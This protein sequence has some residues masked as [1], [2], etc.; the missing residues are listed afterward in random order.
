RKISP[1]SIKFLSIKCADA[2][3]F[4]LHSHSTALSSRVVNV[5]VSGRG[6]KALV[7]APTRF[8][9]TL[10]RPFPRF[11]LAQHTALAFENQLMQRREERVIAIGA[12]ENVVSI[13]SARHQF[14]LGQG[15]QL[16]LHSP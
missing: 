1:L 11:S 4:P 16:P 7:F 3:S 6:R 14:D 13:S 12:V 5:D 15:C 8:S 10:S 9:P 2:A